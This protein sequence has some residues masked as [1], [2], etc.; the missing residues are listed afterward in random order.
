MEAATKVF[1]EKGYDA[2]SI[3]ELAALANTNLASINYHFKS[4]QNLMDLLIEDFADNKLSPVLLAL[5]PPESFDEFKVRID[6]FIKQF[7]N[8][9]CKE[10]DSFLMLQKNLDTLVR[11]SP[12]SFKDSFE[13]VHGCFLN[14]INHGIKNRILKDSLD[15]EIT[16]QIFFGCFFDLVK[17]NEAR[18]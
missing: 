4:K 1:S 7:L 18:K 13:K 8:M 5:D 2:A 9:V 15:Q 17:T 10:Y 3:R 11:I 12:D 6:L 14:F 16:T